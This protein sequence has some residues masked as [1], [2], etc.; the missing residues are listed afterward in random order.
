MTRREI[1][2]IVLSTFNQVIS[3]NKKTFTGTVDESTTIMGAD[4]P[5]DSID[6]VSFIVGI[7]QTMEDDYAVSITLA[8]DRAMSQ[9]VS[10]FKSIGSIINYIEVL[11]TEV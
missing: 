6:L 8:D 3:D 7:E 11:L 4:S 5:F 10:P 9:K 1:T 2:Q